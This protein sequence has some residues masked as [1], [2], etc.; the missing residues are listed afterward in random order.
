MAA[1]TAVMSAAGLMNRPPLGRG[2]LAAYGM[3]Y[4]N[5]IKHNYW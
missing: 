3:Y 5:D 1:G 2:A 4:K